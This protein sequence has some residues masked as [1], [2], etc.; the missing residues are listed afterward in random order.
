MKL[1]QSFYQRQNVVLIAKELIGKVLVT[2][3]NGL[4]TSG[5]IVET[6]A[7]SYQE[8]GCHAY[9]GIT[10]RNK[11]MFEPGGVAYVY[12]CYGIHQMMNVVTNKEE[13]AEAVLI[14]ALE[15]LEGLDVMQHRM[16]V[17]TEK[18]ITSGPGKL[19]KALGIDRKQNGQS[20]GGSEI[21][22]ENR[23]I[24]VAKGRIMAS[25]RIGIDYAGED[26]KLPWRFTLSGSEWVSK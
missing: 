21:W 19:T 17:K 7:Y 20:L 16:S 11:V 15:P 8:R 22:I 9:R 3:V 6:E 13:K 18:R 4:L 14:R 2:S 5:V 12:L 24:K 10:E 23:N 26:A 1:A 25:P